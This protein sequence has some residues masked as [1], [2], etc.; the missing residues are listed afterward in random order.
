[1]LTAILAT[2]E[3]ELRH[4]EMFVSLFYGVIDPLRGQLRYANAGH[5]HAFTVAADGCVERLPA[6]TPPLG[7]TAMVPPTDQRPWQRGSDLLVLFTDGVSDA[8]NRF[9]ARL[10]ESGITDVVCRHRAESPDAILQQ[11]LARLQQHMGDVTRRDDLTM[12][13]ARA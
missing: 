12:V 9:D 4:T 2:I 6:S 5:P 8:R 3:E 10:G 13:I 7:M 1:M 11:V